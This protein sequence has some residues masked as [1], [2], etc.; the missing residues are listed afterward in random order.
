MACHYRRG[1]LPS[2]LRKSWVCFQVRHLA[3]PDPWKTTRRNWWVI[4]FG[5]SLLPGTEE[6]IC[7]P[8]LFSKEFCGCL[9]PGCCGETADVCPTLWLL[10]QIFL[11]VGNNGASWR[12][13]LVTTE[14]WGP[15]WW[16]RS[17]LLVRLKGA[18]RRG[19]I[20]Y[21]NNWL[22]SWC[23]AQGLASTTPDPI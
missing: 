10:P 17:C 15:G 23:R 14:L 1:S 22:Q 13:S 21:A 5:D 3:D 16:S 4:I 18:K 11:P 9:D 7:Q 6:P 2:K 19:L 12:V 20:L 8:D